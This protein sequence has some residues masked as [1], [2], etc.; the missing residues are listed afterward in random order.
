MI[1]LVES[2][3]DLGEESILLANG[4]EG[5][6]VGIAARFDL[7]PVAVYDAEKCLEIMMTRDGSTYLEAKEHLEVNWIGAWDGPQ[8]PIL[9]S[10]CRLARI[11]GGPRTD[12]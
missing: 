3:V 1:E 2:D 8:S 10:G 5:A 12:T 11:T 6:F 4:F 9:L 7:G